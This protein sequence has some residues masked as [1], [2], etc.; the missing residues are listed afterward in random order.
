MSRKKILINKHGRDVY[1]RAL[2]L[3][4]PSGRGKYL[5]WI[6][7][8]IDQGCNDSDIEATIEWFHRNSNKCQHKDIYK[9][10]T[11]RELEDEIKALGESSRRLLKGV[12]D[13]VDRVYESDSTLVLYPLTQEAMIQYGK[14]TAW[15]IS[16][17]SA[18]YYQN[19]IKRGAHFYV[20]IDKS[21]VNPDSSRWCLSIYP[22]PSKTRYPVIT[23]AN[24][25]RAND[26]LVDWS[27]HSDLLV[28]QS[29]SCS[30]TVISPFSA[31]SLS[32]IFNCS[33]FCFSTR[34]Y[35]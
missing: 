25:Y 7:S 3:E 23:K 33:S 14:N 30:A 1:E 34:N 24:L 29:D 28:F 13:N 16:M 10:K 18:S 19:Y 32:S 35:Y 6:C 11:L 15:C 2:R 31:L 21:A 26:Q 4:D 5:A 27:Y 12:K 9:Y 8:A 17:K 22:I 20:I